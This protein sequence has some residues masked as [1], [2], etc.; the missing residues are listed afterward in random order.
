M[1]HK[2]HL[3]VAHE[4]INSINDNKIEIIRDEACGGEQ[5]I[6]LFYSSEKAR[7]TEFSNPDIMILKENK[8]K[9]VIE[10]EESN[11][12]PNHI[13]GKFLS[14]VLVNYYI[15]NNNENLPIVKSDDV[16]FIQVLSKKRLKQKSKKIEQGKI[17]EESINKILPIG[18]SNIKEYRLFYLNE[19]EDSTITNVLKYIQEKIA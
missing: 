3:K 4:I 6:P 2:L 9:I 16:Y 15:H 18:N 17:I 12:L 8:I 19:D 7:K 14:L 1:N 5:H 11:I 13:F 10:I